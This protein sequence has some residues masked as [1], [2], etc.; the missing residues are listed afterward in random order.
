MNWIGAPAGQRD[1]FVE[2]AALMGADE[3]GLDGAAGHDL[4]VAEAAD[5]PAAWAADVGRAL[6]VADRAAPVA[7]EDPPVLSR[8]GLGEV[9]AIAD[10]YSPMRYSENTAQFMSRPGPLTR[11]SRI[12]SIFC[13]QRG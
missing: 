10:R 6:A 8:R 12:S 3:A 11:A 13:A 7:G 9:Q 1:P 2:V 5:V 4:V